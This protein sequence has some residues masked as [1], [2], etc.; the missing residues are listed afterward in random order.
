M[1]TDLGHIQTWFENL[2]LDRRAV[3]HWLGFSAGTIAALTLASTWQ[4]QGGQVG[5]V[6]LCDGWGVPILP[7]P[8]RV[9]RVCHDRWT[10]DSW[11][12][13]GVATPGFYA[14]PSVSHLELWGACDRVVGV[15][16]LRSAAPMAMRPYSVMDYWLA[17][18]S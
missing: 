6:I 1:P 10:H 17:C 5:A 8:W 15:G 3:L 4:L 14:E 18:L 7:N 11:Q 16:S 13:W 9:Y 2:A 12:G